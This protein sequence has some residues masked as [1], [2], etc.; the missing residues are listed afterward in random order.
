MN[1]SLQRKFLRVS[2]Q[3]EVCSLQDSFKKFNGKIALIFV[4]M[5]QIVRQIKKERRLIFPK[6]VRQTAAIKSAFQN[7][8]KRK[9]VR[10]KCPCWALGS[11]L[12]EGVLNNSGYFGERR[13]KNNSRSLM[14]LSFF[15]FYL[16]ISSSAG[17]IQKRKF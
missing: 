11:R 6:S 2:S 10:E 1:I 7:R 15:S 17:K 8:L 5:V 3:R 9:F 12:K 13:L 4:A 14:C 16:K